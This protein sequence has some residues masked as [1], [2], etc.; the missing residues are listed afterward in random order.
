MYG[1]PPTIWLRDVVLVL[2]TLGVSAL[3]SYIEF[4]WIM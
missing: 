1:K 3:V 2:I 4:D